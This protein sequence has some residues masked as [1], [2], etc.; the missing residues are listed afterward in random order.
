MDKQMRKMQMGRMKRGRLRR[1]WEDCLKQDIK[2]RGINESDAWDRGEWRKKSAPLT[3]IK[4]GLK[5]EDETI[6]LYSTKIA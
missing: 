1:R 3:L 6:V 2:E 5:P 4:L